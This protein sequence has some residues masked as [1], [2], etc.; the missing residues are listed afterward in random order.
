MTIQSSVA[1]GGFNDYKGQE[2]GSTK[3]ERTE[4]VWNHEKV[5]VNSTLKYG[6]KCQVSRPLS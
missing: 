2:K 1:R 6:D 3:D 4:V 5:S